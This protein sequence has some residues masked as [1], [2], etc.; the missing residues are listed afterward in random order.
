MDVE[1]LVDK[2]YAPLE[3]KDVDNVLLVTGLAAFSAKNF[4]K[5]AAFL[6]VFVNSRLVLSCL[7]LPCPVPCYLACPPL[8]YFAS[9][10]RRYL[11]LLLHLYRSDF[12]EAHF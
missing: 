7:A 8:S 9:P 11:S 12:I 1:E 10:P 5:A 2:K 6:K 4:T 3:H